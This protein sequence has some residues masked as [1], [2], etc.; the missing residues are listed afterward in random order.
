MN[1]I[2]QAREHLESLVPDEETY[3]GA[4]ITEMNGK[5]EFRMNIHRLADNKCLGGVTVARLPVSDHTGITVKRNQL[6][7]NCTIFHGEYKIKVD[8]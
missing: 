8:K 6:K 2:E 3:I 4:R 7:L 5:V 1:S